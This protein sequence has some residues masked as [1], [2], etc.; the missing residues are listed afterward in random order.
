[1]KLLISGGSGFVGRALVGQAFV[2][3]HT[4]HVSSRRPN[5]VHMAYAQLKVVENLPDLSGYDAVVQLSGE[6][7][8]ARRWNDAQKKVIKQSRIDSAREMVEALAKA[9][10]KPRAYVQ[11]SAIGVYGSDRG[12]ELLDESASPG[13]DFLAGV[14]REWEATA[15]G[16]REH[17]VATT[18]LRTGI[19]LGPGGGALAQ[20]APPFKLGLGGPIGNGR[21]WMSWIHI[22]D[23]AR[24]ILFAIESGHDGPLNG[25]APNAARNKD[26]TKALGRV[27]HRPTIFPIPPFALKLRFGEVADV[28][29]GSLR[30]S[31]ERS[32]ANGFQFQHPEL[33]ETLS[34]VMHHKH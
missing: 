21:Q 10:Q 4:V 18:C 13:D 2:A 31:A 28:L 11:G 27:L 17:G 30:C 1:M 29:T 8:F 34:D 14:C 3:G 7:L 20:M 9:E 33:E 24:M 12:E 6:N 25:V 22:Q 5:D 26:F 32:L 16:A 23:L 15:A 19:V